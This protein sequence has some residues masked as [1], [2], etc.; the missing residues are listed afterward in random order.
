MQHHTVQQLERGPA[1]GRYAYTGG[2]KRGRYVQCCAEVWLQIMEL[3]EGER[4]ASPLWAQVGHDNEALAYGHMRLRLL[5]KLRLDGKSLD[6]SGCKAPVDGGVCD[7]PTKYRAD[8]PPM[9]F[10]KALCDEHR[11][12]ETVE[13]MWDGPGDSWG[14]G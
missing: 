6:W 2:N 12:R 14:S 5:S 13:A 11:T 1:A 7:V 9:H 10:M 4:D 8:I 3:P